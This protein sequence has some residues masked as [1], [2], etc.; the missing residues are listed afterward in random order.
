MGQVGS[1][2]DCREWM[3]MNELHLSQCQSVASS[4]RVA[5]MSPDAVKVFISSHLATGGIINGSL[6]F[7]T[8]SCDS[9]P[10]YRPQNGA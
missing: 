2:T 6:K 1:T 8:V 10:E 3:A 9:N 5:D 4:S 7:R